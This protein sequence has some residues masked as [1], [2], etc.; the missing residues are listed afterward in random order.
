MARV[1][2]WVAA[3]LLVGVPLAG[4]GSSKN[5]SSSTKSS[6][7]AATTGTGTS[8]TGLTGAAK[9]A[10]IAECKNA[11]HAQG[12][13][14]TKAKEKLEGVCEKAANGDS[15]AVKKVAREVCEEVIKNGSIPEGA[16]R[17]AVLAACKQK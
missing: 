11:I 12:T 9:T 14:P 13:L 1:L 7:P 4:C 3:A 17:Q 15:E 8:S 16:D 6:T 5:T 2:A 10:A